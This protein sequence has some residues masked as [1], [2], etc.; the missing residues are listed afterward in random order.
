MGWT[1]ADI[2]DQTGKTVIVTGANS[3]LGFQ[4]AVALTGAGAE[5][6]AT[7]RD[8]S[9]G[10]STIE[11]ITA[12][13]PGGRVRYEQ[14]DLSSLASVRGFAD[15]LTSGGGA[16][17][18]GLDVL[19][20]N[21]GVMA[22]PRRK[23]ADGFEMQ[24]ATNHL[25]HFALTGLLM[26]A[27]A[28]KPGARVVTVSSRA[29]EIGHMSFDDLQGERR[30]FR[31]LAYAQ[32]K[33]ANLLFAFEL[34]RRV[35]SAGRPLLS[36]AAHP[37]YAATNLQS[38]AP[39]M[40]GQAFMGQLF[41]MGNRMFAQSDADGAL[42]QL[43]AA[44]APDVKSGEYYGPGGLGGVRGAPRIV[45]PPRQARDERAAARLWSESEKLTGVTFDLQ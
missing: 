42:P 34:D 10:A 44:T 4:T 15:R 8:D 45:Q 5:V 18:G 24:F 6:V 11:R 9:K 17:A 22:I 16:A 35:R 12:K 26:P 41:E 2:P 29:A 39:T 38:V 40:E 7:A 28:K 36:V 31:W 21:A 27:L 25:G 19:V 3:G 43:R 20:N 1:I 30:Y 33:L 23:S 13:H 14:L 37:G 32:S